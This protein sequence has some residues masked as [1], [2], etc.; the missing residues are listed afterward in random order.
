MANTNLQVL[1]DIKS[2]LEGLDEAVAKMQVLQVETEKLNVAGQNRASSLDSFAAEEAA[3]TAELTQQ[4]AIEVQ[5]QVIAQTKLEITTAQLKG[6]AASAELLAADLK[7]RTST[8]GVMRAQ[9]LSKAELLALTE[10][11]SALLAIAAFRSNEIAAGG[12]L[13]GASLNKAR[14]EAL[15]LSREIA[16]GSVNARTMGALLGSLGP[17]LTIAGIAGFVLFNGIKGAID[18]AEKFTKDVEKFSDDIAKSAARMNALA[19]AAGSFGDTA[20]LADKWSVELAQIEVKMAEFRA[21]QLGFWAGFVDAMVKELAGAFNKLFDKIPGSGMELDTRGPFA[22]NADKD[23][24]DAQ[25]RAKQALADA[26]AAVDLSLKS[27]ADWEK[28][29]ANLSQGIADYTKKVSDLQTKLAQID[30]STPAGFTQYAATA[31]QL[32]LATSRLKELND[33]QDKLNKKTKT[34]SDTHQVITAFLREESALLKAIRQDQELVANNPFL[35]I[36]AKNAETLALMHQQMAALNLEVAKGQALLHGGPLD[37]ATYEQVKAKIADATFELKKLNQE[38]QTL[39]FAGGLQKGLADWVNGFG[40]AAHQVSNLITGTINAALQ[41]TN[42]LLLDAVFRTGDWKQ[43][44]AG[45]E[46]SILNMFLTMLEQMAIQK[47]ASLLGITTTTTANVVA[48]E[49][50]TTAWAPAAA[51]VSIATEGEADAVGGS[52]ALAAIASIVGTLQGGGFSVGGYTGSVGAKMIAGIVHG[53][54]FVQ[55]KDTVDY[56]GLG[57]MEA[58]R[59]RRIPA[60][61]LQ[62]LVSNGNYRYN[63]TPRFGSFSIGG[64]VAALTESH[65]NREGRTGDRGK[66]AQINQAM[67]FDINEARKWLLTQPEGEKMIIDLVNRKNYLIKKS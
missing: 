34:G 13:A 47:V 35:S 53:Q 48:G 3:R 51:A 30:R 16:T 50:T 40:T 6:D 12:L 31:A 26:N 61:K 25:A 46:R 10:E 64:A 9:T 52:A 15:T 65:V 33:D 37:Q 19:A 29:Q 66:A 4:V 38:A 54:E 59:Q 32:Q 18:D 20:H 57:P 5:L 2:K 67:F 7:I 43:T 24:A 56:Y 22:R 63:V 39:N 45:L 41:S 58:L 27:T 62:D 1:I 42:Q 36:D 23:V 60:G 44:V 8:L 14:G 11:E 21:R 28:A 49:A 17:T 55:P